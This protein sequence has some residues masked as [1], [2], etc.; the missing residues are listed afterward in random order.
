[1]LC[2]NDTSPPAQL[3]IIVMFSVRWRGAEQTMVS[4]ISNC[5]ELESPSPQAAQSLFMIVTT[6]PDESFGN[7]SKK[8]RQYNEASPF[9]FE[10]PP[11]LKNYTRVRLCTL[12][13]G[14]P[15][16]PFESCRVI[17]RLMM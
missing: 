14:A 8:V 9:N 10:E 13:S 12:P 3:I 17:A 5:S 2:F 15:A 16:A 6:T 4:E 11:I 1:M 7:F